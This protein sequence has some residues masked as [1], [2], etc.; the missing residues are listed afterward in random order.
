MKLIR[1]AIFGL[2]SAVTAI[3]GQRTSVNYSI[4]AETG[5]V[6]GRRAASANYTNDGSAATVAGIS[7]VAAPLETAKHGYMGQLYEVTGLALNAATANVNEGETLQLG[8]WHSLDDATFLSVSSN[9][10]T[11]TAPVAPIAS[12]SPSGLATAE[13]VYQDT[14]AALEGMFGGFTGLFNLTVLNVNIDDFGAYAGDGIADDWQVQFF[15]FD[16]PNA[17]PGLDPDGDGATNSFEYLA[18]LVPTDPN[19]VLRLHLEAVP[20]QPEMRRIIFAPRLDGRTYAV[21]SSAVLNGA[22]WQPLDQSI[23]S[24]NGDERTVT[25]LTATGPKKFYRIEITKP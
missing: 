6:G 12:I 22:M 7:T 20:G 18:G 16:N 10:V 24:D 4:T 9:L 17:A 15:G 13:L 8:A 2:L 11:W 5:D 19:S 14:P 3:A 25:D 21:K 23:E 1:L